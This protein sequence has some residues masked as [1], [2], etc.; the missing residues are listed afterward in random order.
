MSIYMVDSVLRR[1]RT[2]ETVA[3]VNRWYIPGG[4]MYDQAKPINLF[5]DSM[6][7]AVT[8]QKEY[9]H[10]PEMADLQTI[11]SYDNFLPKYAKD[12]Q[13]Y[14]R[15]YQADFEQEESDGN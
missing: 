10:P 3:V 7:E 2:K 12:Y 8:Y 9:R 6:E 11:Q 5:F 1:Y 4:Y 14:K 15:R 13:D